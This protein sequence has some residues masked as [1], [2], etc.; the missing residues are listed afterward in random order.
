M[1]KDL[2]LLLALRLTALRR[3]INVGMCEVARALLRP[4]IDRPTRTMRG[5]LLLDSGWRDL[6]TRE[7]IQ[8]FLFLLCIAEIAILLFGYA[9]WRASR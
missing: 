2:L 9:I 6:L 4:P 3:G 5:Q 8:M 7:R 1:F